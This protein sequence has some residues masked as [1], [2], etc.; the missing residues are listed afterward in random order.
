MTPLLLLPAYIA[1]ESQWAIWCPACGC[2][3]YHGPSPGHRTPHCTPG[4]GTNA[5][6]KGYFLVPTG[7]PLPADADKLD[8]I[9]RRRI[10][11]LLDARIPRWTDPQPV[12]AWGR[13]ITDRDHALS[14]L[15]AWSW[16]DAGARGD[17]FQK[18][19]DYWTRVV[20]GLS[21]GETAD[22]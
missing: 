3:H 5:C 18:A 7:K 8:R 21:E 1:S 19:M 11:R 14:L 17:E 6:I 15:A 2:L 22:E 13:P 12:P 9:G 10:R 20:L 4:V 16:Q